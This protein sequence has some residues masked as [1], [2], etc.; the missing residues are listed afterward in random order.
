MKMMKD[1]PERD[2]P[3]EKIAKKGV[4]S[5]SEQELIESILGRGTRGKDVR[6]DI[7]RYLRALKGS[8]GHG[9]VTRNSSQLPGSARQRLPRSWRALSWEGAIVLLPTAVSK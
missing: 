4:T 1:V 7:Q 9:A 8:R 6:D 5:L 3:R 2:R